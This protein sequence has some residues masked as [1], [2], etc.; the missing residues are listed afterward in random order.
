MDQHSKEHP[1]DSTKT[2]AIILGTLLVLTVV[3]AL[4]ARIDLGPFST[5]IALGIACTKMMF[6]ALFFMHVFYSRR[7]I[8]LVACAALLWLGILFVLTFADYLSRN[9]LGYPLRWP[10]GS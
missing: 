2:Y 6:V 7:L 4:V 3:T 5:I 9:W 1:I 8:W 10:I